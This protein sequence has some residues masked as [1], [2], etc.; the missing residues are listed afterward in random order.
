ML[1]LLDNF[2]SVTYGFVGLG[3]DEAAACGAGAGHHE[4]GSLQAGESA[5]H[6]QK[7]GGAQQQ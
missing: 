3:G 2:E 7:R 5:L 6:H 4:S 1:T